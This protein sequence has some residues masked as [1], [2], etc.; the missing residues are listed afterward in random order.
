MFQVLLQELKNVILVCGY[1]SLDLGRQCQ[2]Q[3]TRDSTAEFE[4]RG[5]VGDDIG[6][7]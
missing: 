4:H 3:D 6:L 2:S 5:S 1:I 7:N